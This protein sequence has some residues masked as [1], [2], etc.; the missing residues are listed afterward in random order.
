VAYFHGN[1]NANEFYKWTG[2][3]GDISL[4]VFRVDSPMK[5]N[6][7]GADPSLLSYQV[8]SIDP[9]AT[10]MTVREYRWNTKKWGA[11]TTVSLLPRT[12]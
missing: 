11:A 4:N 12:N 8:I 7:S 2:P 3:N 10:Q 5:G 9:A 1:D 6:F